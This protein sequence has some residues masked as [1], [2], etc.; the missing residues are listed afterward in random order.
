[1]NSLKN[2]FSKNKKS[3][4]FIIG[5]VAVLLLAFVVGGGGVSIRVSG[6]NLRHFGA[7]DNP[8]HRL[9]H[10]ASRR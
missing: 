5:A 10:C 2:W 8:Q 9:C 7:S 6:G 1:M 3:P 4:W